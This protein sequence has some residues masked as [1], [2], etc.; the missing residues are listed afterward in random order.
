M[1]GKTTGSNGL[2]IVWMTSAG[3]PVD[4]GGPASAAAFLPN[5]TTNWTN[6]RVTSTAPAGAAYA[7][8]DLFSCSNKGTVWFSDVHF[9]PAAA[10]SGLKN[11]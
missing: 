2:A 10:A 7:Q 9:S 11:S 5:G 8:I 3:T 6:L 4:Y 1:G